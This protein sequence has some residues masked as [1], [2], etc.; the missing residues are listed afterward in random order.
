MGKAR[1]DDQQSPD[2]SSPENVAAG[3]Q[4]Y[5]RIVSGQCVDVTQ[6]LDEAYG[7]KEN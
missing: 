6:E 4:V 5:D 2:L 7:R 1:N 3:Q